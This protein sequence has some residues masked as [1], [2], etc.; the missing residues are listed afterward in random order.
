MSYIDGPRGIGGWLTVFLVVM[1]LVSPL[2]GI[3][4]T[5]STLYGDPQVAAFYG[6]V[7]GKIE[8]AEWTIVGFAVAVCWGVVGR[9]ITVFRWSS[10]MI[11]VAGIWTAG[12]V[13]SFLELLAVSWIAGMPFSQIAAGVGADLIRPFVFG[14]IWTAYLLRSERVANTYPKVENNEVGEV[15]E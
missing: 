8:I 5:Y 14:A 12:V 10:V 4:T 11:A 2:N 6:T 3:F 15:F 7:W 1:G 13:T 9:L